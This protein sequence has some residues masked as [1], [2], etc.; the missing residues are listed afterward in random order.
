MIV[1]MVDKRYTLKIDLKI[2]AK[3]KSLA[4][5]ESRSITVVAERLLETG[6]KAEVDKRKVVAA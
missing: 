6:I 4:K 1:D 2:G 5:S 3:L